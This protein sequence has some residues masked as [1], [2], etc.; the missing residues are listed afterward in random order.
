MRSIDE[1]SDDTSSTE[2]YAMYKRRGVIPAQAGSH[3]DLAVD[4][5]RQNGFPRARE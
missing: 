2:S 1:I 4:A 5:E 3:L